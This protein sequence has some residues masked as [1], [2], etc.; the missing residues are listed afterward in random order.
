VVK[1]SHERGPKNIPLNSRPLN[2][3]ERE[4][5]L[6]D[7][8]Y[9]KQKEIENGNWA[10][11]EHDQQIWKNPIA[12]LRNSLGLGIII[13]VR[14]DGVLVNLPPDDDVITDAMFAEAT[15]HTPTLDEMSRA[16]CMDAGKMGH[17]FCGWCHIHNKP[18]W[19]CMH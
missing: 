4:I 18:R 9:L 16:N 17:H 12:Q 10:K 5:V 1:K 3:V 11:W 13:E 6:A 8:A 19:L 2:D 7:I 14:I 15:G